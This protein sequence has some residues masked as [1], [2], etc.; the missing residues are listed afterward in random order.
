M[1]N[2]QRH[3][4]GAVAMVVAFWA[5]Q[6]FVVPTMNGLFWGF[7]VWSVIV[8]SL[9]VLPLKKPEAI[10]LTAVG[11]GVLALAANLYLGYSV[12]KVQ[13]DSML[14]VLIEGDVLLIENTATPELLGIYVVEGKDAGIVKRLVG[15][16]GDK[17]DVRYGRMF[18]GEDEVHPRLGGQADEWN[19]ERPVSPGYRFGEPLTL[20][21]DEYFF[22]SDNPQQGK[23]SRQT[24][25]YGWGR[26]RGRVV[27][28]LKPGLGGVE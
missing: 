5:A 9:F 14:P 3:S 27:M 19:R 15:K 16:S 1:S 12:V 2:K 28:R 17:L 18:N 23:D 24:G 11:A 6:L 8:A 22:L 13:G 10:W 21:D 25:P 26:V 20:G 7:A 4:A